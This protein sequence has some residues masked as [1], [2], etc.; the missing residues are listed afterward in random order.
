M[1]KVP[2]DHK[3]VARIALLI[4]WCVRAAKTLMVSLLIALILLEGGSYT[5]I[6][7]APAAI[8]TQV[9]EDYRKRPNWSEETAAFR[10]ELQNFRDYRYESFIGWRSDKRTGRMLNIDDAGSRITQFNTARTPTSV[11]DFYGGSTIWGYGVSD[12]NTVP[13]HFARIAQTVLARN[14]GEQAYNSRQELNLLLNNL[15]GGRIGNVVVFFDGANDVWG[16]CQSANGPFGDSR[17]GIIRAVLARISEDGQMRN[18]ATDLTIQ[19]KIALILPNTAAL[20]ERFTGRQLGRE[21]YLNLNQNRSNAC[22]D[23]DIANLVAENLVRNWEAASLIA[24]H[25]NAK[26]FAILQPLPYT[27]DV[28]QPY[29]GKD[30]DDLVKAIYP[31]IKARAEGFSWFIDGTSWLNGRSDLYIDACCHLNKKGN[32]IIAERI[33]RRTF[34]PGMK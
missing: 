14:F 17:T 5:L 10:R 13:S 16:E 34:S 4:R 11:F 1:I 7:F 27:A 22:R 8:P 26:F 23:A 2:V 30:F 33:F 19:N 25:Y 21:V 24:N 18:L 15:V 32:E 31:L 6:S 9:I 28:R 12:A 3:K 29:Y 20:V